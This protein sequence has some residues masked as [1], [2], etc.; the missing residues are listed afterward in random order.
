[1]AKM[2]SVLCVFERAWGVGGLETV[3]PVQAKLESFIEEI[4]GS[5]DF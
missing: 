3:Q 2:Q 1:M 5:L 4:V